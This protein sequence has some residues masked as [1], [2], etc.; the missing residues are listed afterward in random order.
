MMSAA[1]AAWWPPA[2]LCR[3]V[4]VRGQKPHAPLP[5]PAG[6]REGERT[7]G[8]LTP[9]P[10][11]LPRNWPEILWDCSVTPQAPS[12]SFLGGG[13]GGGQESGPRFQRDVSKAPLLRVSSG[14][15]RPRVWGA[16][17]ERRPPRSGPHCP[18]AELDPAPPSICPRVS[19]AF[20]G[21]PRCLGFL[22][23]LKFLK[24]VPQF[25]DQ[26]SVTTMNLKP[27]PLQEGW[28]CLSPS[29]LNT[30]RLTALQAGP[31]RE[32]RSCRP[33]GRGGERSG[34]RARAHSPGSC[35]LLRSQLER[36]HKGSDFHN[37]TLL[38]MMTPGWRDPEVR[39]DSSKKAGCVWLTLCHVQGSLWLWDLGTPVTSDRYTLQPGTFSQ[40]KKPQSI[41]FGDTGQF[42]SNIH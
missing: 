29:P 38:V 40:H 39:F 26:S 16:A 1:P 8:C 25:R 15:V 17:P 3:G 22:F 42:L 33:T 28:A 19:G 35:S 18:R 27:P 5:G 23:V 21:R 13:G 2:K 10:P 36:L 41:D 6:P 12:P 9:A 37:Q 14:Q 34:C 24:L 32:N 7:T 31:T 11:L 20:C 4:T 30:W